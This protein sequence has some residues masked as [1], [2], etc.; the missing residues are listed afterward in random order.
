M[1]YLDDFGEEAKRR[2]A[3]LPAVLLGDGEDDAEDG[4]GAA[5]FTEAM[6]AVAATATARRTPPCRDDRDETSV[7]LRATD[8]TRSNQ[9]PRLPRRRLRPAAMDAS[10]RGSSTLSRSII[11]VVGDVAL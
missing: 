8:Y 4:S 9:L 1:A 5:L 6:A 2:Y 3:Q 7:T 11:S 10:A